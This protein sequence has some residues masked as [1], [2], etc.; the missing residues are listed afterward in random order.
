MPAQAMSANNK[1]DACTASINPPRRAKDIAILPKP[2]SDAGSDADDEYRPTDSHLSPPA[3]RGR[4]PGTMSRT[5][6]EAQRKLNH[7]IIE[8]ARRT[9][10]NDALA[11]LRTLV[12]EHFGEATED[13]NDEEEA[14]ST[15][16]GGKKAE[17]EKEF[18]LEI[19]VR[20][21]SYM[22][23]LIG[24]VS[25]LEA[26]VE[27][28]GPKRKRIQSR[29]DDSDDNEEPKG[30][31]HR[32]KRRNSQDFDR[33]PPISSW[34]QEDSAP[35]SPVPSSQ[36]PTPPSST[37]FAPVSQLFQSPPNFSLS[38]PVD[39]DHS[40]ANILLH[41]STSRRARQTEYQDSNA[42][43]T[44]LTPSALLGLGRR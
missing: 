26:A 19:L 38:S 12:P 34:L 20:T 39:D 25:E 18:K 27:Q 3:K 15:K 4:K 42:R 23:H 16:P 24:R 44:P 35:P 11:T 5:A 21:V 10:I 7:S 9:K 43:A 14:A 2:S 22:Q 36:L 1:P 6:R 13:I 31:T 29:D 33:L 32:K 37:T 30:I 41:M 28:E 40:A 8:K 17:K